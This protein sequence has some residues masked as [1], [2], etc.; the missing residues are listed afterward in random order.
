[1]EMN[2]KKYLERIN[3]NNQKK[4]VMEALDYMKEQRITFFDDGENF[5]ALIPVFE[6][7][8]ENKIKNMTLEELYEIREYMVEAGFNITCPA[9]IKITEEEYLKDMMC[10][11]KSMIESEQKLNDLISE[12]DV[13]IEK[14]NEELNTITQE[15]GQDIIRLMKDELV[16]NPNFKDT[17]LGK[18]YTDIMYSFDRAL[19]LKPVIDLAK[20]LDVENTKN[21]YKFNRDKIYKQYLSVIKRLNVKHDMK[22]F[23][24]VQS[25]I[26]D[27]K[28]DGYEHFLIFILMKYIAKRGQSL[29]FSKKVDGVF[30]S[31]LCTNLYLLSSDVEDELIQ[32]TFKNSCK[33]L[34]EIYLG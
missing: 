4:S 27:T 1:M 23:N 8:T 12:Y 30:A 21:D 31:Q 2:S 33:E 7:V 17:K 14:V 3:L 24:T 10:Y 11:L 22:Q 6:N 16:K 13:E 28:Y 9:G 20:T 26:T 19:D 18:T 29:D 34:L 32:G 15:Y 25:K 5:D